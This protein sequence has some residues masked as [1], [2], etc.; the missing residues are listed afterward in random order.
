LSQPATPSVHSSHA[1]TSSSVEGEVKGQPATPS[2][3]SSH[4]ATSSSV[5]GEVKGPLSLDA[6]PTM[7]TKRR[8]SLHRSLSAPMA[9]SGIHDSPLNVKFE[10]DEG[11][12]KVERRKLEAQRKGFLAMLAAE[13][14]S[15]SIQDRLTPRPSIFTYV[16]HQRDL[17]DLW[18][19]RVQAL[20][21][22]IHLDVHLLVGIEDLQSFW[23]EQR[24]RWDA[25]LKLANNAE[26]SGGSWDTKCTEMELREYE[27]AQDIHTWIEFSIEDLETVAEIAKDNVIGE[28]QRLTTGTLEESTARSGRMTLRGS[29]ATSNTSAREWM[30]RRRGKGAPATPK[31]ERYEEARSEAFGLSSAASYRTN[32]TT[33]GAVAFFGASV[34]WSNVFAGQRGDLVLIAWAAATFVSAAVAAGGMGIIVDSE[35]INMDRDIVARRFVRAFA[36]CSAIFIL[37]GITMLSIAMAMVD[38]DYNTS[39]GLPTANRRRGMQAAGW[40]TLAMV[41]IEVAMA[42]GVRIKYATT[43]YHW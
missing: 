3:H 19:Q 35:G 24:P 2:I 18:E 22:F 6:P 16:I 30:G 23:Q 12:L 38:P 21:P 29:T 37:A 32:F 17:N 31:R 36:I 4:A 26:F 5:E 14:E 20:R 9:S 8:S 28:R 13:R 10:I 27:W 34:A 41:L 25:F 40:F 33:L 7:P 1:A 43:T 11:S 15:T 39:N 42:I